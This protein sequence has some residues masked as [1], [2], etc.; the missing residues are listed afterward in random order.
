MYN[1]PNRWVSVVKLK[2]MNILF[3]FEMFFF[4]ISWKHF[5]DPDFN[6]RINA[7]FVTHMVFNGKISSIFPFLSP[8]QKFPLRLKM[9]HNS[10]YYVK[11]LC[12]KDIKGQ[13]KIGDVFKKINKGNNQSSEI[14]SEVRQV[15]DY[16]I[17]EVC[18]EVEIDNP[19]KIFRKFLH[20]R[21]S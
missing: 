13:Q 14:K 5:W 4:F 15:L 21:P 8:S 16:I 9:S 6:I 19:S 10:K 3:P 11:K 2:Y 20:P 1:F 12:K 17:T 18:N 7:V